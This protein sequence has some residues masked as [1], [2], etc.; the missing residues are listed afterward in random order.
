MNLYEGSTQNHV[1]SSF[2]LLGTMSCFSIWHVFLAVW[3]S[4]DVSYPKI[5]KILSK[6][7]ANEVLQL[8]YDYRCTVDNTY[9]AIPISETRA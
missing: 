6:A 4:Y 9:A 3:C 1:L 7:Y 8:N 2:Q 5:I